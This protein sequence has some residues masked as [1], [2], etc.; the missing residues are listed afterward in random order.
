MS[1]ALQEALAIF[2]PSDIEG[3]MEPKTDELP[4]L[5]ARHAAA[6]RFFASVRDKGDLEQCVAVL[7]PED[8][9]SEFQ[10]AFRAF[11]QSMDMLYPDPVALDYAEDLG[12]LGKIRQAAKARYH[13]ETLDISD[14]GDKVRKLIEEAIAAEGVQVLIK[15]VSLFSGELE[16]KLDSLKS[17]EAKASEMEHAI[18]HEIH[19]KLEE[20]PA[21]YE[22]LR[23]RL[24]KII[25]DRKAQRITEAEQ[26][27][28]LQGVI[29]D[30]RGHE[31]AAAGEGMSETG[32]AIYGLLRGAQAGVV[33][34]DVPEYGEDR[35][36]EIARA[37]E[38]S[39]APH[40]EIVD[41]SQ[42][43]DVQREMRRQIKRRL[44]AEMYGKDEQERIAAA[45][46]DLL[47]VRKGR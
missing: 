11:S 9:R 31:R 19:V 46:I 42:K 39:V 6:M 37:I 28:L 41:W 47:R 15:E 7:E 20:D 32:F 17:D 16:E 22:S 30:V 21:Y 24:Q 43:T 13:D 33:A 35:V 40:V 44:P 1:E 18:R 26:L 38:H 34:D 45:L 27:S 10:T 2:S 3:A 5:Q 4:R 36:R 12:W 29:D 23:D 25:E 14:C 8:V